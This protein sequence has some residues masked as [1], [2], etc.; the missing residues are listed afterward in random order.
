M[1]W[2]PAV[3][4]RERGLGFEELQDFC[5][6]WFLIVRLNVDY[7]ESHQNAASQLHSSICKG[8]QHESFAIFVTT[9]SA[10]FSN[11][12]HCTIK[13]KRQKSSLPPLS[14]NLLSQNV[15]ERLGVSGELGDTLAQLLDGHLLLVEVESEVGLTVDVC[16]LLDVERVGV[17]RIELLGHLI[18]GVV[19]LLEQVGLN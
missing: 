4:G 16:L 15:L 8:Y 9:N 11:V 14:L 19:Q 13:R 1:R 18:L 3:I 17:G 6:L 2:F 12:Y 10:N 5:S 7:T